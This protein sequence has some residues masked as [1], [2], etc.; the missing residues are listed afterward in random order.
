MIHPDAPVRKEVT[1]DPEAKE[2]GSRGAKLGEF[3]SKGE[4]NK[5]RKQEKRM[6]RDMKA[7]YYH[8]EKRN[9]VPTVLLFVQ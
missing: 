4:A 5:M 7:A 9:P 2:S 1:G 8:K 3:G 6:R